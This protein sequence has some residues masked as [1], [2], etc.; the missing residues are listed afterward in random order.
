MMRAVRAVT[1]VQPFRRS[2]SVDKMGLLKPLSE[3]DPE[4]MA[5][6]EKEKHRQLTSICLTASEN[7][8]PKA[9][10]ETVGSIMTNKYSEGYPGARYYGGNTFIDQS[11]LLCQQR[12][13]KAFNV[14][15]KDW[16]VNVQGMSGS[17]A[18]FAVY[19]G[20]LE[21]FDRI[22]A[23]DLPH[24]GHLSH[25]YQVQTKDGSTKKV[26]SV[27]K[28]FTSMPYRLDE[29]TGM[30]DYDECEKFA[31]RYRPKL[32]IAGASAYPREYDYKRMRDIAN[33]SG[34]LLM[35]DMAHIS[36]LV[37]AGEHPS[38]FEYCDVVTS[39]T[40]KLLR[41]PRGALIFFKRGEGLDLEEKINAAVFPGMQG[42]PHNHTIAGIAVAL[43]Q[44]GTPE[45]KEYA[46]QVKKNAQAFA[47]SLLEQ[48][49]DL[50]S[51]GTDN[52]LVLVNLR[53]K[54]LNGNK[55]ERACELA[56]IAMN[57]NTVPGDTSALAPSGLRFGTP[58]MTSRGLNEADFR[59]VGQFVGRA[60]EI[61]I[62]VQAKTGKKLKDFNPAIEADPE[63]HALRQVV[64]AFASQ[65][66]A[67]V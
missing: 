28:F 3:V 5:I 23:L 34:S 33:K 41:G 63:M 15:A 38:P 66:P 58:A 6:I 21:P 9:V 55:G 22:M 11:E 30:I 27:S 51:G 8:A 50:V 52:H 45:F 39:T 19:A 67:I 44:A 56:N 57:K 24:G 35:A 16:G 43:T 25:G 40:H 12:A 61:A 64:E 37:A 59:Q 60:L 26:S 17:P 42:G 10:M 32:L 62:K 46:K 36:G 47:D 65:F 2:I 4:M 20:I 48:S 18:N 7:F 49:Y 54:G 1:R 31:V 29:E 53:S 13:L 14:D